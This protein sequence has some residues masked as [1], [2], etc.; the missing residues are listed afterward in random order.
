MFMFRYLVNDLIIHH[1]WWMKW[2]V[3]FPRYDHT[4]CFIRVKEVQ[5]VFYD[6]SKAFDRV[7]HKVLL[8]KLKSIGIQGPLLSWI[9]NYLSVF[10]VSA[11]G[12]STII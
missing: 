4:F 9:E 2:A 10:K 5:V 1:E 12:S 7:W 11:A 6:V 3:R 8:T